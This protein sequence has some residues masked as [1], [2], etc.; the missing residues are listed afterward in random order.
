MIIRIIIITYLLSFY[1]SLPGLFSKAGY[2]ALNGL[3]PFY[4]IYILI[5]L[6]E[7]N[8]ILLIILSLG[9]IFLPIRGYIVTLIFLFIPFLI[10]DAYDKKPITGLITCILPFIMF[11]YISYF[12]GTYRYDMED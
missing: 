6:L 2:N 5:E 8:P 1:I 12:S 7:I 3:I 11:P 10:T 9:L 4:N